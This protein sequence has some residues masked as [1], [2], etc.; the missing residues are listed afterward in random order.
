MKIISNFKDYY[1]SMLQYGKDE[2]LV[3]TRINS[4]LIKF[5]SPSWQFNGLDNQLTNKNLAQKVSLH[6]HDIG[7][8]DHIFDSIEQQFGN[9][10]NSSSIPPAKLNPII[11][12]V[13]GKP[14][15]SFCILEED[16]TSFT[17]YK[18]VK[19]NVTPEEAFN[20][21]AEH[22]EFFSSWSLKSFTKFKNYE[23]FKEESLAKKNPYFYFKY[24]R[25]LNKDSPITEKQLLQIHQEVDSPIYYIISGKVQV[26]IPLT[27]FGLTNLFDNVEILHQ[28]IAYCLGNVIQNKNEPPSQIS[29]EMKILQHGFDNKASFRKR[30]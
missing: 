17:T 15:K 8:Y 19:R 24:H 27:Y 16:N 20:Y 12:V 4:Q 29:N 7:D 2:S 30:K 11:T 10:K 22:L 9:L 18:I 5:D 25:N 23:Q 6:T 3:F 21:L 1:D 28:E 13:N 14:F 26:N